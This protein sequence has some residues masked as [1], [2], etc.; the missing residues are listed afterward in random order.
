LIPS[1]K[2]NRSR[3]YADFITF[4]IAQDIAFCLSLSLK[5]AQPPK[6]QAVPPVELRATNLA[7]EKTA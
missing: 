1:K 5:V 6:H 7:N 2:V 4:L 3:I